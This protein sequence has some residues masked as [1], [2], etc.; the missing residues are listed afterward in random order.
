MEI[1]GG[2]A[3]PPFAASIASATRP[4][5]PVP[6]DPDG[7]P[8]CIC[9]T[10]SEWEKRMVGTGALPARYCARDVGCTS[11]PAFATTASLFCAHSG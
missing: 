5:H 1:A 11:M 8:D 7:V 4:A 10:A 2:K 6:P 9:C 3:A